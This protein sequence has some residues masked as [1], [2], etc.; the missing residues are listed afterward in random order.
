MIGENIG[1]QSIFDLEPD[2]LTKRMKYLLKEVPDLPSHVRTFIPALQAM[3]GGSR[4]RTL[5]DAPDLDY[6][7]VAEILILIETFKKPR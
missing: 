2:H 6:G 3:V 1:I 5:A 7:M 4:G